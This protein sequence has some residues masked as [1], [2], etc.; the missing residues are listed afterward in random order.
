MWAGGGV[1]LYG[2]LLGRGE[3]REKV[4]RRGVGGKSTEEL[5]AGTAQLAVG[6]R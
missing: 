6:G 3:V 1:V 2:D 4:K 5:G